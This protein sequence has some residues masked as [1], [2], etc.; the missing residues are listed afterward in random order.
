[1]RSVRCRYVLTVFSIVCATAA[2]LWGQTS[3][4]E[5]NAE[6]QFSFSLPGARSLGSGGAFIAL[7]DDATAAYT[8]PAGLTDLSLF[9]VSFEGRAWDYTFQFTEGGRSAGQVTGLGVDT[10]AGIRQGEASATRSGPSF[11]SVVYPGPGWALA[12]YSHRLADFSTR[13]EAQGA[14]VSDDQ[15]LY[16][17]ANAMNLSI[18][19]WGISAGYKLTPHFSVGLGLSRHEMRMESTTDRYDL[20][21]GLYSAPDETAPLI[22]SQSRA[23]IDQT[24]TASA[25]VHWI[26]DQHW[27]TGA[28]YRHGPTFRLP[29]TFCGPTCTATTTQFKTP[30]VFGWGFA[31][32]LP[33]QATTLSLDYVRVQYSDMVSGLASIVSVPAI[34]GDFKVDTAHEFHLGAE[35]NHPVGKSIG[36]SG[37]IG[38]WL[39]PDHRIRYTG[40]D[41]GLRALFPAGEDQ[42][43]VTAGLGL[44]YSHFHE[45]LEKTSW[46]NVDAAFDYSQRIRTASLSAV[47]RF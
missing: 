34:P 31:Y 5:V 41:P 25:G 8:N 1:M 43:H 36:A 21:E 29:A 20:P 35:R 42:I 28:V 30:D 16:P 15:R 6:L 17:T 37:R 10:V 2:D 4:S 33:D 24:S 13:F 39:D 32:R 19:N 27:R 3:V 14:F 7:A 40:S 38:A 11:V 18:V 45:A 46:L 9:E 23:G 26:I 12:A 47:V 22:N 44:T